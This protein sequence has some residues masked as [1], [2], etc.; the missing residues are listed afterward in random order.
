MSNTQIRIE[1]GSNWKERANCRF[2]PEGYTRAQ[3]VGVF[4]ST[5]E[6]NLALARS[7]CAKCGVREHCLKDAYNEAETGFWGGLTASER[8]HLD[9]VQIKNQA[10]YARDKKY[11]D[12]DR[13]RRNAHKRI[14]RE[15]AKYQDLWLEELA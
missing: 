1:Q 10:R 12:K 7:V 5:A 11:R 9:P 2:V 6:E 8:G 13:D 14:A 15:L 4:Y 3:W